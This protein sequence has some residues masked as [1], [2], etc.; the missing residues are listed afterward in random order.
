VSVIHPSKMTVTPKPLRIAATA[1]FA[2]LALFSFV[3]A[4]TLQVVASI[5]T[6]PF[7]DKIKRKL[8]N[9]HIFRKVSALIVSPLNPFWS[10]KRIGTLP[11]AP[12]KA[13]V[14]CNHLSNADPFTL[15]RILFPWETKYISK[16]DLFKVPFGGWAMSM[17]G[18]LAIHF[19]AEK[20]GWGVKK[21]S[22]GPMMDQAKTYVNSGIFIT[23]F[24]EGARSPTGELQE[25]KDGMFKLATETGA[26]IV[27]V[28]VCGTNRGWPVGESLMDTATIYGTV[29]E[30]IASEGLTTEQLR[31]K[32]KAAIA[33][34]KTK[35]PAVPQPKFY[36]V[37]EKKPKADGTPASPSSPA[38][39][40]SP[41]PT[42]PLVASI[43]PAA[44]DKDKSA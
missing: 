34:L 30:P 7:V 2:C 43:E 23:V 14:M 29:G 35:L 18:D 32:V 21:G 39:P 17:A 31:D 33:E 11:K 6:Y 1:W 41:M 42:V 13:I 16:S 24:P 28:A 10:V 5:I 26:A 15:C 22:I 44:N 40:A 8:I 4:F 3:L 25:F 37:K 19:T 38:S 12:A 27:P 9:G 20:G 36:P